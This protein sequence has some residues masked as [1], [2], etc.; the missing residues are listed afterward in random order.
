MDAEPRVKNI[1]VVAGGTGGHVY[2]ALAVALE[3]Q[4]RGYRIHWLGTEAGLEARVVPAAGI[5]LHFLRVQGLRGKGLS[6]KLQGLVLACWAVLQALGALRR[7]QPLCVLGMGGYVAGP[8]GM[9]CRILRKPL[10]IHEQNSVAGTTNRIL[11]RFARRV[12][13]A[14]PAAFDTGVDA[15]MVGNPVRAEVLEC[16][17]RAGYDY[18]GE[19]PLKLL[20]LGGSLGAR[21]INDVLPET[22]G[23]L[24]SSHPLH[25]RHQ[26]GRAHGKAVKAAY[27]V[28]NNGGVEV[29]SY[30]E[31]MAAAY[32]WADLVLCRAGALTLAELTV[33]GRPSVLVPLPHSIDDHQLHNAN[34][35]VR[36]GAALLLPQSE[37]KPENLAKL[38]SQLAGSPTR[39]AALAHAA[40]QSAQL[41]ATS[42]VADICEEV[43]FER[44]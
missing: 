41:D 12:L 6:A 39:L 19:R 37:L 44:R 7:M 20:V 16:G 31:D 30:I 26:T 22:L 43:R 27:Q 32:A 14:Y 4:E 38:L 24:G 33:M 17:A 34:W 10:L 21:A 9:A 3:L 18:D 13:S 25:V 8:V 23:L 36:S 28:V 1:V 35:L 15:I 42:K 40:T 29:V 2:P 5:E 11:S